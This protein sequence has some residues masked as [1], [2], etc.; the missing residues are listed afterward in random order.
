MVLNKLQP[1]SI[2]FEYNL[3]PPN[4]LMLTEELL[5]N[6]SITKGKQDAFCVKK[7]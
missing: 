1:E 4:E 5:K 2:N 3:L 6:Y 7:I